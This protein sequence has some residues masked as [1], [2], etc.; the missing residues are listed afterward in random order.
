MKDFFTS[1]NGIFRALSK[2][3]DMMILS[4]L[5]TICSLP[6]F[7]IGA[8]TAALYYAYH[9][10]SRQGKGYAWQKFL[11]AFKLNFKQATK[12]WIPF[13]LLYVLCGIEMHLAW[14]LKKV[15]P[16]ADTLLIFAVVII[17]VTTI[18]VIYIFPYIARIEDPIKMVL[19]N[20]IKISI[21][22]LGWTVLLLIILV[23]S[24]AIFVL[25]KPMRVF[26]PAI[27]IWLA[28]KIQERVFRKYI[29]EEEL[30]SEKRNDELGK[31]S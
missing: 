25:F 21:L 2:M 11:S 18:W 14:S 30:E 20:S 15:L 16:L 17:I 6:I 4:F 27:Y 26:M 29:T 24:I 28:N 3:T 19:S 5:W 9:M 23:S 8:S 1:D 31:I 10:A 7:T 22:N 12:I 13:L